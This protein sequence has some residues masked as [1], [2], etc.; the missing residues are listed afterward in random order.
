LRHCLLVWRTHSRFWKRFGSPVNT[1]HLRV[2][3]QSEGEIPDVFSGHLS[4]IRELDF[5]E[6]EF[7]SSM[8]ILLPRQLRVLK[9]SA[10]SFSSSKSSRHLCFSDGFKDHC[11][12]LEVLEAGGYDSLD[13]LSLRNVASTLRCL[14]LSGDRR[15]GRKETLKAIYSMVVAWIGLSRCGAFLATVFDAQHIFA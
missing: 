11:P 7:D 9:C 6:S 15:T 10:S 4:G 5:N 8:I 14:D 1:D 3:R 12:F 13:L 2:P